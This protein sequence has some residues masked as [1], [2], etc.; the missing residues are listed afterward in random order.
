MAFC[1]L[2]LPGFFFPG[3]KLDAVI[4]RVWLSVIIPCV[5]NIVWNVLESSALPG[6]VLG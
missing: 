4:A 5:P 1:V 6:D 2:L 3:R